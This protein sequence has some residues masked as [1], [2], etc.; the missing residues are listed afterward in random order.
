[1]LLPLNFMLIKSTT[2]ILRTLRMIRA[3][4]THPINLVIYIMILLKTSQLF[5][6]KILSIKMIG[7]LIRNS[8]QD[9]V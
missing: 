8:Q 9:L 2:W 3:N 5:Q 1:M 7:Q 6:L 4:N